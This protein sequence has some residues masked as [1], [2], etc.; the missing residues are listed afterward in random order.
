MEAIAISNSKEVPQQSKRLQVLTDHWDNGR[1]AA[2]EAAE[3]YTKAM[4]V[5][6][7]KARSGNRGESSFRGR[8]LMV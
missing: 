4:G 5:A 2:L 8:C 6:L 7:E 1:R 3:P